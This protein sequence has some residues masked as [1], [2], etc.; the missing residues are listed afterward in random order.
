MKAYWKFVLPALI[1]IL[2]PVAILLGLLGAQ[3][4]VVHALYVFFSRAAP[5]CA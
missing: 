2:A 4:R 3:A 5:R 1:A